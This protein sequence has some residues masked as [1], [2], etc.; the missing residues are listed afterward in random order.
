MWACFF[1]MCM[2]TLHAILRKFTMFGGFTDNVDIT[3]LTMILIVFCGLA[4]MESERGHVRVNVFVD[5]FPAGSR[6][7]VQAVMYFLTAVILFVMFFAV[8][9][10]IAPMMHSGAATTTLRIPNWPFSIIL[11][12]GVFFYALTTL[13]HAIGF[14][15]KPLEEKTGIGEIDVT[16]QM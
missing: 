11:A 4:F 13:L 3:N 14:C 15:L 2:T 5:K 1:L 10:N 6:R 7:A 12:I 8:V 16:N 9:K